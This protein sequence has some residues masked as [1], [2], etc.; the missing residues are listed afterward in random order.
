MHARI[1]I[2]SLSCLHLSVIH[3]N[4]TFIFS[5]GYGGS[6][7]FDSCLPLCPSSSTLLA[8]FCTSSCTGSLLVFS[9]HLPCSYLSTFPHSVLTL[10]SYGAVF[11]RMQSPLV[12]CPSLLTALPAQATWDWDVGGT[13]ASG[14]LSWLHCCWAHENCAAACHTL[15]VQGSSEVQLWGAASHSH[16][17]GPSIS[18]GGLDA[19]LCP[20]LLYSKPQISLG[21]AVLSFLRNSKTS[22][23]CFLPLS[24]RQPLLCV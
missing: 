12:S 4:N 10:G 9:L 19:F 24:I 6:V 23:P 2:I 1:E 5:P 18:L 8:N 17:P 21:F 3:H 20:F 11:I 16:P 15:Q 13:E 7:W 14:S 22:L